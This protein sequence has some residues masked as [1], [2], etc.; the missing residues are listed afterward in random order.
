MTRILLL[1][2]IVGLACF[3]CGAAD[4][5]PAGKKVAPDAAPAPSA[6][7]KMTAEE[8]AKMSP[9]EKE[10]REAVDNYIADFDRGDAKAVASLFADDAEHV[11]SAGEVIRGRKAIEERATKFLAEHKGA[12]LDLKIHSLD[13]LHSGLA[14]ERG[15]AAVVAP[16]LPPRRSTMSPSTPSTTANGRS[17]AFRISPPS[18]QRPPA[19]SDSP[20]SIG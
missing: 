16:A 19:T 10:V 9:E 1:G 8:R 17:T 11:D 5:P 6:S 12:K 14:V 15:T 4:N 3:A 20:A 13:V 2:T 7:A 18:P